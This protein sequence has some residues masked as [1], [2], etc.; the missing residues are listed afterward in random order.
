MDNAALE[1]K[2]ELL[3][4]SL[5]EAKQKSQEARKEIYKRLNA[6]EQSKARTE[7]QYDR[8]MESLTDLKTEQSAMLRRLEELSQRPAK[9]YET[10]ITTAIS[11]IVGAIIGFFMNRGA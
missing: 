1:A 3:E 9:R 8:I 10:A 4:Q 6:L 7:E 5:S 2:L 11:A